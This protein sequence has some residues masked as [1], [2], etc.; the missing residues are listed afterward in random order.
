MRMMQW[1]AGLALA[2]AAPALA[3]QGPVVRVDSGRLQGLRETS[4]T[5]DGA[6]DIAIFR[7]V[8]FAAAP[9]GARRWQPPAPVP[10]WSGIRQATQF[11]ARCMQQPLFADMMFRSPGVSEDCLFLNVWTPARLGRQPAAKLPVLVYIY[12]GGFMAGD[13]SEKRY[14]GAALARRGIV[15][16]TLNYR[17]GVFG[18]LAHPALTAESPQHASGNYGLLDQ[19]AALSWVRRNVAAFGGDPDR[20]TIGGESAGSM[21]VSALMVSPLSRGSI[22]GAIGESGAVMHRLSPVSLAQA[23]AQGAAFGVAAGIPQSNAPATAAA[24]R[25]LSA[26]RLLAAQGAARDL[27]LRPVIDGYALTEAPEATF[28]A[29]RAARVPL[30]VGTNSQ[31]AG[32]AAL[33][34]AATPSVATYRTALAARFGAQA[35]AVFALYPAASDADVVPAATAM[36]S[37]AFLALPT[38]M[39][40]DLSRRTGAPTYL[41]HYAHVRPRALADTSG[42][43]PA[44][45]A[46]HSAEIEYAL[47]NLDVNPLYGW[48]DADRRVSAT[49]SGYFADFIK[50]GDPNGPGLPHWPA[51]T[52]DTAAITRQ[53]IDVDTHSQPFVEQ[54]RYVAATPLLLG[55][56]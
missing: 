3:Q 40:F 26:D 51:A 1:A 39:W 46:V 28:A 20:I 53:V 19:V 56:K 32:A 31:E 55:M 54:R 37:D 41:Y 38:W 9:V 11:G 25:A 17:L 52:A 49:M 44:W 8:P 29:G 33:L 22:A 35:D 7:G 15:V 6:G 5:G 21:S 24:M 16:V 12:G 48:T 36:A 13:G 4:Q 43:P 14:D 18:W 23:E 47:G 45:G 42:A 34:G 27:M 2:T 50:T 10:H 30:L